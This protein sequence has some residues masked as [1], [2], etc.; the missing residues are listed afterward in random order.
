KVPCRG[1]TAAGDHYLFMIGPHQS[2][3]TMFAQHYRS[4]VISSSTSRKIVGE[5]NTALLVVEKRSPEILAISES[6]LDLDVSF[7]EVMHI[8][9]TESG[10]GF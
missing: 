3:K 1:L 5:V 2:G 9:V 6:Y 10:G 7:R 4:R 8:R